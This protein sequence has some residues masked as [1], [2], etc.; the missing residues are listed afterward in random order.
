M[1]TRSLFYKIYFSAIVIFVAA[2][3]IFL[4]VFGSWLK[5]YEAA[6]PR[7]DNVGFYE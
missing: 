6:Q 1:R 3:I 2:L 4:F 5:K 7:A